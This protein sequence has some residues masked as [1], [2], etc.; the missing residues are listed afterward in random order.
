M[1]IFLEVSVSKSTGGC[2]PS[3]PFHA[4]SIPEGEGRT[5]AQASPATG[6]PIE[7]QDAS[8]DVDQR[9]ALIGPAR[10]SIGRRRRRGLR[11]GGSRRRGLAR[12]RVG[13]LPPPEQ[14]PG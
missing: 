13:P 14:P 11:G 3:S 12:G 1:S 2:R 8:L 6:P 4:M 9:A 10:G 7:E 5:S